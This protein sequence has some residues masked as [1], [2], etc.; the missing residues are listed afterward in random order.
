MIYV[1]A[2]NDKEQLPTGSDDEDGYENDE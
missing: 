1:Q 2:A